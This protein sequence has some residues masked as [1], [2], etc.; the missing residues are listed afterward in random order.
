V[1]SV[2]D[3]LSETAPLN[4]IQHVVVTGGEPLLQSDMPA[5]L[6][7]LNN[8]G[9]TITVETSGTHHQAGLAVDLY[10]LS[11]KLGN[12]LP[13]LTQA[14]ARRI[15]LRNNNLA[16]LSGYVAGSDDYQLKFVVCGPEDI[17]EIED[18]VRRFSIPPDRVYLMPEGTTSEALRKKASIVTRLC[19]DHG[20]R[21]SDRLQIHRWGNR[22]GT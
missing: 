15:H 1:L 20:F 17:Q 10:S 7:G 12:S 6:D 19:K 9:R 21:F 14:G 8:Q 11:P 3:I 18:L 16:A 22:P 5:L 2:G 13:G 4:H